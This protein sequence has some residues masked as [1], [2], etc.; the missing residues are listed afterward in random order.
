MTIYHSSPLQSAE[1]K[2]GKGLKESEGFMNALSTQAAKMKDRS[3]VK[4]V[5][6]SSKGNGRSNS[7][8]EPPSAEQKQEQATLAATSEGNKEENSMEEMEGE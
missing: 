7:T 2:T 6:S 1:G 5:K 3:K 4:K 8:S